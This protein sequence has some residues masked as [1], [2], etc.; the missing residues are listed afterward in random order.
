MD[1]EK[2]ARNCPD[3]KKEMLYARKKDRNYSEKLNIK[4]RSCSSGGKPQEKFKCTICSKSFTEWRSQIT[5]P[6]SPTCSAKCGNKNKEKSLVGKSYGRLTVIS[7]KRISS[8][9]F[10]ECRCQCGSVK[11]VAHGGLQQGTTKSCGCLQKEKVSIRCTK[12][13]EDVVA[14][15]IMNYYKRNAKDRNLV[16]ELS[17]DKF[18]SLIFSNCHYCG[19]KSG[20]ITKVAH[21]DKD[22]E[23]SNNGVDRVD[24]SLGYTDSNC[25]SC[26]K[27]CNIAKSTMS[28]KDFTSWILKVYLHLQLNSQ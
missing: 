9:T 14:T 7:R 23:L 22:N 27:H 10:Y 26:C 5:N 4:C 16:W 6:D 3:C 1:K 18:K 20:T 8:K 19:N 13:L 17:D 24:N 28:Y 21:R 15:Q 2:F 12:P 11:Y 25:V